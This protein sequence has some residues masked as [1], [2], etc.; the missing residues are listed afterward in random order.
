MIVDALE[1]NLAQ[2]AQTFR[3]RTL[4]IIFQLNNSFYILKT[5]KAPDVV[6]P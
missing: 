6:T 5:F 4:Q 2:K 1:T 3:Q